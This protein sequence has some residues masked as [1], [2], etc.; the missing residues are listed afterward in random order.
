MHRGKPLNDIGV[1][2]LVQGIVCRAVDDWRYAKRILKTREIEECRTRVEE[3]EKFFRSGWFE[4]LTGMNGEDFITTLK[5]YNK[6]YKNERL[7][8]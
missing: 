8:G 2:N 7:C 6:K 1:D 3:C 4:L 5:S